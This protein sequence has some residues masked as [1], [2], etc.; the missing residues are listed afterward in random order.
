MS[1]IDNFFIVFCISIAIFTQ[2]KAS[3]F[4]PTVSGSPKKII[5]ESPIYLSIV[6]PYFKA[7]SDIL[8]RYRFN[9]SVSGTESILS[10]IDVNET[11][12]EKKTVRNF[13]SL[14][15]RTFFPPENIELNN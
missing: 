15:I 9:I 11:M 6:P 5:T 1:S 7:I 10:E 4:L 2:F 3:L 8:V 14:S 12:S 13:F